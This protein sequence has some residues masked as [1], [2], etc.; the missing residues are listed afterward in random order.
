M[1]PL[2]KSFIPFLT[3]LTIFVISMNFGDGE[4]DYEYVSF[5]DIPNSYKHNFSEMGPGG[6][7][8]FTHN[9]KTYAFI[10]TQP[11]EIVEVLF[12]GDAEDGIGEEVRYKVMENKENNNLNKTVIDGRY[13][14]FVLHIIQL[15]K[16]VS[17]P[18]GFNNIDL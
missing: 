6:T 11:N 15:E 3:I 1:N 9:G 8:F 13:G 5:E 16:A 17:T 12:V 10:G 7:G 18:F 4:I 14:R 2:K